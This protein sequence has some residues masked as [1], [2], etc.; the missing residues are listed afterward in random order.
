MELQG[1]V[2]DPSFHAPSEDF[3][4]TGQISRLLLVIAGC[5]VKLL[6]WSPVTQW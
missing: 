1:P 4:Q 3:Y 5:E 6:V 2:K